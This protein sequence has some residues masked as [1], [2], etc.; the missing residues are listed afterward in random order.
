MRCTA[1]NLESVSNEIVTS[2]CANCTAATCQHVAAFAAAMPHWQW[3][4]SDADATAL[5]SIDAWCAQAGLHIAPWACCAALMRGAA[6]HLTPRGR[7]VTYGPYL[8]DDVPTA[9]SNLAFDA[10]LRARDAAWGIRRLADV[11]Q[12]AEHAGLRLAQN[13]AM[14][15]NNR[16]LVFARP[17]EN[18]DDRGAPPPL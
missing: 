11:R 7:L 14:P 9:P 15:A 1:A 2:G 16:L 3:Q 17:A 5:P 12:E 13:I 10:S 8:Q 18:A 4:P 6:R